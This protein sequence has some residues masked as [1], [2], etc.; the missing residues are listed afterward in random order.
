MKPAK[1]QAA[2]PRPV[3]S[4]PTVTS[5]FNF[6]SSSPLSPATPSPVSSNAPKPKLA[7]APPAP[8]VPPAP[9]PNAPAVPPA[10]P[11]VPPGPPAIP[12]N[13]QYF[14]DIPLPSGSTTY[15]RDVPQRF[16]VHNG[17]LMGPH[18]R[19]QTLFPFTVMRPLQYLRVYRMNNNG[20]D[21]V[22]EI[23]GL[24]GALTP[25]PGA[26]IVTPAAPGTLTETLWPIATMR[27]N[28][29]GGMTFT[30]LRAVYQD[31]TLAFQVSI[32]MIGF[33]GP[34]G[35]LATSWTSYSWFGS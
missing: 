9:V 31:S 13:A 32:F 11:P 18:T 28:P 14:L 2:R 26:T 4:Q 1:A 7:A 33:T 17:D 12:P 19:V 10:V 5:A 8:P 6:S 22:F 29:V 20:G 24:C 23:K 21:A 27:I 25:A 16:P 30:R 34:G 35:S 3:T 15:Y